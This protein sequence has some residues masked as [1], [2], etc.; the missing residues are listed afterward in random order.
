MPKVF[1]KLILK[2]LMELQALIN[3]DF[4]KNQQHE[5]KKHKS[6]ATAVLLIQSIIAEHVDVNEFLGIASLDLSAA[7]DMVDIKLLVKR[8][9]ILELPGDV[10]DLIRQWLEDRSFYISIEGKTPL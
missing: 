5:F 10:V 2:R 3:V 1:E 8:L 7:I 6:T 4:T 9:D